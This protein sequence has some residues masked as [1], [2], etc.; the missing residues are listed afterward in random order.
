MTSFIDEYHKLYEK[1]RIWENNYWMG[2]PF[3]KLPMDA[4]VIQE[5]IV[6]T[7]PDYIIETGT[8]F[9]GSALFYASICELINNG[10]VV[11]VDLNHRYKKDEIEKYKC[12]ERIKF[13]HGGSTNPLV[14]ERVKKEIDNS[15]NCMVILDSWHSKEHVYREMCLYNEFVPIG[16]YMIVED[17]HAAGNPVPWKYD[18]EGPMGAVNTWIEENKDKWEVDYECEKH[19]LSFNPGGYIRRVK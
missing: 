6:K 18:D 12:S 7:K 8:A 16:G 15:N 10:K 17:T 1:S 19:L 3:F 5:L 13:V 9:G 4:M 14:I 2:V 11:T